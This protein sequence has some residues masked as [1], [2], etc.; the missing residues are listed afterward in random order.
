MKLSLLCGAFGSLSLAAMTHA[1][2]PPARDQAQP[3][4]ER[5]CGSCHSGAS[6]NAKPA[7]LKIFDIDHADWLERLSEPQLRRVIGRLPSFGVPAA[8]Q[9]LVTRAVEDEVQRRKR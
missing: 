9:T 2:A 3:V 4:I 5:Y 6:R 8:E 1:Q 7:A